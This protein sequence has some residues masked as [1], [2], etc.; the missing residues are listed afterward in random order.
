[1][2]Q[3]L[4]SEPP[5]LVRRDPEPAG[6]NC[7]NGGTAIRTGLDRNRDGVLGDDEIESTTYACDHS[8]VPQIRRDPVTP[9]SSDCE[10]FCVENPYRCGDPCPPS[11][12]RSSSVRSPKAI[13]QNNK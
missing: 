5:I 10:R 1:V 2:A 7:P 8:T 11:S 13:H 12:S 4:P 6:K 9:E 3:P